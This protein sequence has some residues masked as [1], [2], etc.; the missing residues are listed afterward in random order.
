M[1][2]LFIP[3]IPTHKRQ[4]G[5]HRLHPLQYV[6]R[7]GR[8]GLRVDRV[9]R[10]TS[11]SLAAFRTRL[12]AGSQI[13][14]VKLLQKFGGFV[15]GQYYFNNQW[16]VNGPL[17]LRQGLWRESFPVQPCRLAASTMPASGLNGMEWAMGDN[18]QTIQQASSYPVVS[19]HPGH[20]VRLA[21]FPMLRPTT[22]PLR[23]SPCPIWPA[24]RSAML[25]LTPLTGAI[26]ATT[27][28]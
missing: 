24:R 20:Q 13:Y 26:L 4:S 7:P 17:W 21:V 1:G 19:S 18:A 8:G 28:G 12:I 11:S 16:F 23:E 9:W 25:R 2:S 5:R 10:A 15:Q 6:D 27:I 3:I 22:L 14:D